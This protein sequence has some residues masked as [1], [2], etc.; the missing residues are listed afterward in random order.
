MKSIFKVVSCG[1]LQQVPS[2]KPEG[3]VISKRNVVLQELGGKFENTY[4]VTM[5]G[6]SAQ[7]QLY[8]NEV[9]AAALRFLVHEYNG[10][11]YQD[12]VLSEF[13]KLG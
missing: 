3:G 8:A 9:V 11:T 6:N 4:S 12:I 7:C 5:L 13:H 1:E 10:I 2:G